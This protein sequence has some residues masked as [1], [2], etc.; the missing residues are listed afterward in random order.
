MEN[1]LKDDLLNYVK[2]HLVMLKEKQIFQII[3]ENKS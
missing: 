1:V 2:G 3:V